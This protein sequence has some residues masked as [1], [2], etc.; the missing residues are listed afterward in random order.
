MTVTPTVIFASIPVDFLID[1]EK[2]VT[3][4]A[5]ATFSLMIKLMDWMRLFN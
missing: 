5:L 4:S 3:M 2:L 1:R